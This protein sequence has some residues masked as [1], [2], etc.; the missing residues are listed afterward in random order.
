MQK[1]RKLFIMI[2][3][4]SSY[5]QELKKSVAHITAFLEN[6]DKEVASMGTTY[7]QIHELVNQ[8]NKCGYFDRKDSQGN[9]EQEGKFFIEIKFLST[10]KSKTKNVHFSF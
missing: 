6:K 8:I 1:C 3:F 5:E 2:Y 9:D 10:S 7:K 4:C